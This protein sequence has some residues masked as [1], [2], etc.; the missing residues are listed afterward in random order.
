MPGAD[1]AVTSSSAAERWRTLKPCLFLLT[2]FAIASS[3][4]AAVLPEERAEALYHEYSGG[5][6][7]V[8]GPS[9]LVRKNIKETVS[10]WGNYYVD[11]VTSAS[12]DVMT[13][14]SAY[15]EERKQNSGGIDILNERSTMSI[16]YSR[17]IESDYDATTVNFG[18]SQDFFGDLTTLSMG[19]SHGDDIVSRNGDSNSEDSF[20][21]TANRNRYSLALTQVLT[22]NW[23]VSLNAET[24]IDKGFLNNPYR[25]IRFLR[26]DGTEGSEPENYPRTRNSDAFAIRSMYYLPYR[27]AVRFEARTY[28]DSWGIKA[29]NVEIRYIHPFRENWVFEGRLRTASQ[30]QASFYSDLFP[31]PAAEGDFRARDKELSTFSDSQFGFGITY[32][33]K[34]QYLSAFD[35]ATVNLFYDHIQF[36]YDNFRDARQ[37]RSVNG[38]P[39]QRS[40]GQEDTYGLDA[41]VIRFFLSFWY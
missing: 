35:K 5:D 32:E 10:I 37:S 21:D 23:I 26:P 31:T 38:A 15:T 22:K 2:W 1:V 34:S 41:D 3:T 17:S 11:N 7:T 29:N 8:S 12:I 6:V 4:Q 20:S 33:I 39:A 9:V 36:E 18:V 13:Q 28:T 24:V 27:A 19:Y 16:G 30:N 25:S 40:V 14:G